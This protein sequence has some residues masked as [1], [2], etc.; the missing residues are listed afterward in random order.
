MVTASKLSPGILAAETKTSRMP[1]LFI[2]HGS[3]MNAI[4][5]TEFSRAWAEVAGRIPRPR[6]VLCISA[7]WETD[8]VQVTAMAHPR[9]IY[10]FSGFPD[11]LYRVKYPAPGS[12]DLARTVQSLL[13]VDVVH[14]SQDWGLDH[15]AWSVL[16]RMYPN[17]DIPVVQ[18][19]LDM[20]RSPNAHYEL[21]S[22]LQTLREQGILILGSGN[23]VHN[24]RL[25]EWGGKP[26]DW[27]Q[28]FDLKLKA[29]IEAHDHAALVDYPKLGPDSQLA[30]PTNE[31]Y[32]PMLYAL[33]L[34]GA[35]EPLRFFAEK[36]T[37]GSISM[38]AFQIG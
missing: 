13:G 18:Q 37:L 26:F 11:E 24:L 38:R 2:G 28:R 31:H 29:L 33:A 23:M 7:H 8:G 1:V 5:D 16:R 10:D 36:V 3:P 35:D 21:G 32:L 12:P 20:D 22:R 9:T 27:A 34:Q 17:A 25:M 6:A 30:I 15:G 14:L 4:E 19:S